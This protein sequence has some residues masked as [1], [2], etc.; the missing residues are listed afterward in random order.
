MRRPHCLPVIPPFFRHLIHTTIA[1]VLYDV[2]L[3]IR[4]F[5]YDLNSDA[6]YDVNEAANSEEREY[7]WYSLRRA[8]QLDEMHRLPKLRSYFCVSPKPCPAVP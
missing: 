3:R 1:G 8:T 7:W 6:R 2:S 5:L 4:P